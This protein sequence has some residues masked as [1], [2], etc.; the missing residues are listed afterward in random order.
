MTC[1]KCQHEMQ[2]GEFPFC[3]H[4]KQANSVIGD[5]CDVWVKHG[6]CNLDG[7]AR[8]YRSKSEMA[9]VAKERNV[10]PRVQHVGTKDGD[11]SKFTTRWY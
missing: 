10:R 5:E 8:H 7:T 9:K 6:I 1:E 4:D 2:I 3:P 11:K